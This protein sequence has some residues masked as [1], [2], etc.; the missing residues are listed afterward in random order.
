LGVTRTVNKG[1]ALDDVAQHGRWI[2]TSMPLHYKHNSIEYKEQ[3]A[4][5]VPI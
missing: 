2:T 1:A 4:R 5:L 3:I